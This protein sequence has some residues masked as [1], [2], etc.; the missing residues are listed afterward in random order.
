MLTKT[1][2]R[3]LKMQLSFQAESEWVAKM[4]HAR[5]SDQR[6]GASAEYCAA[7]AGSYW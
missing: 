5:A 4:V 7:D 3:E 1:I 2:A 6:S